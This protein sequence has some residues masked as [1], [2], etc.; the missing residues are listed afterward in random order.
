[1][2]GIKYTVEIDYVQK[3]NLNANIGQM[4]SAAGGLTSKLQSA[5]SMFGGILEKAV[6]VGAGIL[7]SVAA[8]GL[9]EGAAR[10]V[11]EAIGFIADGIT[12]INSTLEGAQIGFAGVFQ[13]TGAVGDFTSAME[14]SS[15]LIERMRKDAAVLPGTFEDLVKITQTM[16]LPSMALGM[17]AG[18]MERLAAKT[19]A[20]GI[21]VTKLDAGTTGREM[22]HVLE[23]S[24]QGRMPLANLITK[25]AA[26]RGIKEIASIKAMNDTFKN[27]PSEGIKAVERVLDGFKDATEAYGHSWDAIWSTAKNNLQT[28]QQMVTFGIFEDLKKAL[29]EVNNWFSGSAMTVQDWTKSFKNELREIFGVA[30]SVF[31]DMH[32]MMMKVFG[33]SPQTFIMNAK[34]AL[35]LGA[36]LAG[37]AMIGAG[38]GGLV[39]T[40]AGG[41]GGLV[42]GPVGGAAGAA[43]GGIVGAG[44]GAAAMLAIT[45]A[46]NALI[47]G[48]SIFHNVAV[49][50]IES[51]KNHFG[52]F[53]DEIVKLWDKVKDPLQNLAESIG[54]LLLKS[55]EK[56]VSLASRFLTFV[57]E[58]LERPS[59]KA[60]LSYVGARGKTIQQLVPYD[61]P[62]GGNLENTITPLNHVTPPAHNTY[63]NKVEIQV[64]SK[65]DPSRI[66]RL[67]VDELQRLAANPT[68]STSS[69]RPNFTGSIR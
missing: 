67:T 62:G 24:A 66:A 5:S 34:K 57:N 55:I 32:K 43:A 40:V 23:G 37:G 4:S 17:S 15:S 49:R 10:G 14:A 68:R 8:L 61:Q 13:A 29:E 36:G 12:G 11:S 53:I 21:G 59:I 22:A 60:M 50:S 18:H 52:I 65:Q 44:Y 20:F 3:G 19:M 41:I 28:I 25:A 58:V 16:S 2:S 27:K 56:I 38:V 48:A 69:G 63:I 64:N 39:G 26:T 1:M 46:L 31:G 7:G 51:I 33:T 35:G 42:A 45:G 47:D 30:K 6:G 54:T 9:F